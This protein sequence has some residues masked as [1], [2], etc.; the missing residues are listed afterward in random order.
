VKEIEEVLMKKLIVLTAFAALGSMTAF[1]A[2]WKGV[3][4]DDHCGA[5]HVKATQA[6]RECV[7]KCVKEG[8]A[9]VFVTSDNKVLKID[10][11]SVAKVTP[12]FGHQVTVKGTLNG[13]TVTIDT[14]TM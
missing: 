10:A 14:V 5:A 9:P 11:K 4:S 13:D 2:E 3:I 12:H 7:Q 1:A 6:D 8:K